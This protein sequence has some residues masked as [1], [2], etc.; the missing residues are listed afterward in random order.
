MLNTLHSDKVCSENKLTYLELSDNSCSE[1]I[2][3]T[4]LSE[5]SRDMT[6]LEIVELFIELSDYCINILGVIR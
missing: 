3:V 6:Q 2:I 4:E 1:S 5:L